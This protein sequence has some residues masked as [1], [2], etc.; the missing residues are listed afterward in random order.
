MI[1]H[2]LLLHTHT[3]T[4]TLFLSCLCFFFFPPYS[5]VNLCRS[6]VMAGAREITA[7]TEFLLGNNRK[8]LH[9][10]RDLPIN[11]RNQLPLGM[12]RGH[13]PA[14]GVSNKR[15]VSLRCRAQSKPRALVS[16]V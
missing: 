4:H 1:L 5:F 14:F 9:V 10:Q 3:H 11:R 6:S 16:G 13:R 15:S 2:A 7:T 8:T 12:L